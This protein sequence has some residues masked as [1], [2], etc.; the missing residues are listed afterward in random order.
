MASCIRENVAS[1]PAGILGFR[2]SASI[3][4]SIGLTAELN[5]NAT[6]GNLMRSV[7]SNSLTMEALIGGSDGILFNSTPKFETKGG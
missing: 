2:F 6:Q 7:I 1:Y 3:P 4:G 5:R